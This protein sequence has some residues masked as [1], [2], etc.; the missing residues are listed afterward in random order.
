MPRPRVLLAD[1]NEAITE[2]LQEFLAPEFDVVATVRNG[3]ALLEEAARLD[4]DVIVA[5]I[6]M[7]L[8]DGLGALAE[9]KRRRPSAK[10][11]LI[12]MYHE[13]A[14]ARLALDEG[15]CGFVLKHLAP[16][17]LVDGLRA[18]LEGRTYVSPIL[19][20]KMTR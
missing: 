16:K 12:T 3:L 6:S 9:L 19:A 15:A 5:D 10:V 4:P 14:L 2:A 11:V 20:S 17:E 18:A 7:P 8:L 1:D 13:P